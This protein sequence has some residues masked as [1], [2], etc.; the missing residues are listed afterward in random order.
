M[1][2]F[3]LSYI[4]KNSNEGDKIVVPGKVLSEGNLSKKL[5]IIAFSFSDSAK[6]KILK[7][8]GSV[9][10]IMSEIKKNPEA[11]GVKILK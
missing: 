3:N 4:D 7:S 9:N 6:E 11:K 1:I 10:D 5:D 8:K 2:K